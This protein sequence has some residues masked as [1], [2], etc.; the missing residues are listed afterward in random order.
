MADGLKRALALAQNIPS[1]NLEGL[2]GQV[3]TFV[4]T[5]DKEPAAKKALNDAL[6]SISTGRGVALVTGAPATGGNAS[7][8]GS[9]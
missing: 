6:G 2:S 4:S 8:G 5:L 1:V 3:E 7:S 9:K